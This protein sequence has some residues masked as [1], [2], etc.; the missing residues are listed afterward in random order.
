MFDD[1]EREIGTRREAEESEEE[2]ADEITEEV[3]RAIWKLKSGKASGVCGI[4]GELLKAGSEVSV[5]GCNGVEDR[6][7]PKRLENSCHC[8]HS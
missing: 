7:G 3:R 6:C 4:Q 2:V 5:S 1:E 8:T